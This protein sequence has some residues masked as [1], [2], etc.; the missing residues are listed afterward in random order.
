MS[1]QLQMQESHASFLKM[2]L[3]I[4]EQGL[5]SHSCKPRAHVLIDFPH[6][7][8]R[9]CWYIWT[10]KCTKC[11][12]Q[13]LNKLTGI[14]IEDV[15][16]SELNPS[17]FIENVCSQNNGHCLKYQ[18]INFSVKHAITEIDKLIFRTK[19][20]EKSIVDIK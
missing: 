15:Y 20:I 16:L 4:M 13:N 10:T 2:A 9:I 3:D 12:Y 17:T 14:R 5:K 7:E 11:D 1:K 8:K 18:S 6:K 19:N